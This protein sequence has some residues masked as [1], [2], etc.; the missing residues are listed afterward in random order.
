MSTFSSR[1]RMFMQAKNINQTQL[2][3]TLGYASPEKI[4]RL[5]RKEG[6]SPSVD[7]IIDFSN[8]F[9]DLNI[10]WLVTGKGEMEKKKTVTELL[11][12]NVEILKV[13]KQHLL[14]NNNTLIN[15]IKEKD[16]RIE[17][18]CSQIKKL[19]KEPVL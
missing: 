13:Q 2:A 3:S 10:E 18:L 16:A 4:S 19:G 6:A 5:L 1:L 17:R 15:V 14:D 7:I 12:E 8:K 11:K 9:E